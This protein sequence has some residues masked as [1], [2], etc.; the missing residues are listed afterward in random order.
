MRDTTRIGESVLTNDNRWVSPGYLYLKLIVDNYGQ[1][2]FLQVIY[3]RHTED[4]LH[5]G[6]KFTGHWRLCKGGAL[7]ENKI[8]EKL[9]RNV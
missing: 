2:K 4:N 8:I 1:L 5:F 3:G 9:I 7:I 6:N